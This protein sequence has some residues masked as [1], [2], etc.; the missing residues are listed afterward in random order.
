[1]NLAVK[2]DLVDRA[3]I[4]QKPRL[5]ILRVFI[6]RLVAAHRMGR[7]VSALQHRA[8][9]PL[10]QQNARLVLQGLRV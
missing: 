1:M 9:A 3:R 8:Q 4:A 5:D 2:K 10:R 6:Q 7:G